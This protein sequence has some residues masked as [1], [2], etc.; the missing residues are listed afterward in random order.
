MC[1]KS[2][3]PYGIFIIYNMLKD[4]FFVDRDPDTMECVWRSGTLGLGILAVMVIVLAEAV[5]FFVRAYTGA[6]ITGQPIHP[7]LYSVGQQLATVVDYV[8]D[9]MEIRPQ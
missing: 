6:E 7:L 1:V 3:R 8:V 4:Y 5:T 9:K 2:F